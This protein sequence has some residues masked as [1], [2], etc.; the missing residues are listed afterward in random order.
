[1]GFIWMLIV[2]L[3][4][5]ALAKLVMPGRQGG[6]IVLTMLL[7]VVGAFVAGAL[8]RAAGWYHD[9]GDGPGIIASTVGALLVLAIYGMVTRRRGLLS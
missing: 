7:G 4:A 5:G 9:P 2:G 6:G 3:I 8:G 1:M